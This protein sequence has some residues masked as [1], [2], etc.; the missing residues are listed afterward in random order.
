MI[1][2]FVMRVYERTLTV[3]DLCS[4]QEL[5]VQVPAAAKFQP[6]DRVQIRCSK[7]TRPFDVIPQI[8]ADQIFRVE[9]WSGKSA[10]DN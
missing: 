10:Q 9:K 8:E 7:I 2:A 3:C 4:L 6:G 1:K 5:S